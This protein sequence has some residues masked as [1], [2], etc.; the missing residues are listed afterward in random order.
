[1]AATRFDRW[2]ILIFF[3]RIAMYANFMVYAACL[4]ILL[5]KWDMSATQ[6]GSISSAFMFGYAASP[7]S[8]L[9]ES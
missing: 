8:Y 1:M 3:A 9:P 2:L 5:N 7:F 6:T 4:P